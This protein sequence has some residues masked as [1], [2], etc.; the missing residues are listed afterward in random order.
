MLDFVEWKLTHVGWFNHHR[1]G[2]R[3]LVAEH[4]GKAIASAKDLS[5]PHAWHGLGEFAYGGGPE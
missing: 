4:Q 3:I 1:A 5:F 2:W